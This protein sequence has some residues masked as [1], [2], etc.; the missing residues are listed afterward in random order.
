MTRPELLKKID[1]A[2]EDAVRTRL[3]GEIEVE[4]RAGQATFL[5]VTKNEKLDETENRNGCRS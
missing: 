3:F 2:I 5:R 4:F 1:A